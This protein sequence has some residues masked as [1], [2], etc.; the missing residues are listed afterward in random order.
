MKRFPPYTHNTSVYEVIA[1]FCKSLHLFDYD[2]LQGLQPVFAGAHSP[3]S[4][5]TGI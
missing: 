1:G 2:L 5:W 4:A 3:V